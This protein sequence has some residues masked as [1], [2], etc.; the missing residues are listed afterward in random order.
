M[1]ITFGRRAATLAALV[2]SLLALHAEARGQCRGGGGQGRSMQGRQPPGP[3]VG[4]QQLSTPL[5]LP[6]LTATPTQPTLQTAEQQQRQLV[7][8]VTALQ[9]LQDDPALTQARQKRLKATVTSAL[10]KVEK[11]DDLLSSLQERQLNGRWTAADRQR[12][13]A[14]IAQQRALAVSLEGQRTAADLAIALRA[15]RANQ[16]R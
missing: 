2:V 9:D 16:P 4:Q 14:L 1:G 11:Q 13:A 8:A 10:K 6:V 3:P 7:A 5:S 12:L 15:L